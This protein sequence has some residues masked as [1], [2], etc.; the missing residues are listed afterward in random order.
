MLKESQL[1]LDNMIKNSI[2][3]EQNKRQPGKN[4]P[5]ISQQQTQKPLS[6]AES[7]ARAFQ[8]RF[9][10]L[11]EKVN[12]KKKGVKPATVEEIREYQTIIDQ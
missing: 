9:F 10:Y 1:K 5:A 7:R 8:E 4:G 2:T 3:Q 12:S 6:D 11:H